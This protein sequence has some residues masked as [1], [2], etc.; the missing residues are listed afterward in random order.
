MKILEVTF[1]LQAGGAER[2][3]V[4]LSNELSKEHNV[5]LL[6]LKDDSPEYPKLQFYKSELLPEVR[7]KNLGM[8]KGYSIKML[9]NVYKAIKSENPDVVHM[10]VAGV[11]MYCILAIMLLGMKVKFYQTIHSDIRN[12]YDSLFYRFF[13]SIFGNL[14]VVGFAALSQKNHDDFC[15]LYPNAK[16]ACIVNGRADIK[17]TVQFPSVQQELNHLKK[18]SN[19]IVYLHVA[20]CCEVKNQSLLVNCFNRLIEEGYLAD[21][22]IIGQDYDTEL[23]INL[24]AKSCDRIHFL[25]TRKNIADYMLASDVFCLSSRFEGM[26]ITMIEA[27]LAG[28]PIVSTPVC[29]ALEVIKDRKNGIKSIDYTEQS[30]YEALKYSY[31]HCSELL[32]TAAI[33]NQNSPYTIK[34]C[35]IK[36]INFFKI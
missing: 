5:T 26:P 1:Y 24:K 28:K 14:K 20:R 34:E 30:Y 12:G 2:F 19:S 23:G 15:K 10:H 4:D 32:S 33:H 21:L 16:S 6:T 31:D 11:P 35:A 25:G 8:P 22:F 3:I 17:P 36:Y 7:Y 18:S 9:W 29:G 27:T 13:I